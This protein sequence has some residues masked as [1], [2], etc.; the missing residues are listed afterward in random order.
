MKS[1]NKPIQKED[2]VLRRMLAT[3]P[4]PKKAKAPEKKPKPSKE[5]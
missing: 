2:D 1:T 5:G 3:K 4:D